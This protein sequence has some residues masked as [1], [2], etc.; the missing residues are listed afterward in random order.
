MVH[1]KSQRF[2]AF[3]ES[4]DMRDEPTPL[5]GKEE[6]LRCPFMP[7]FEY[8]PLGQAIKGNIQF[9]R[10]KMPGVEFKPFSRRKIGWVED[11]VPPVRIV[12]TTR[13]NVGAIIDFG[14]RIVDCGI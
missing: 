2:P 11:A 5:N 7:P 4:L 3:F 8:F 9:D 13:A 1:Q 14:F 10:M 12:I 6:S